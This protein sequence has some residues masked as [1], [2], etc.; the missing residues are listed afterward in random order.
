MQKAARY[1]ERF[2]SKRSAVILREKLLHRNRKKNGD[3]VKVCIYDEWFKKSLTHSENSFDWFP[4]FGTG[5]VGPKSRFPRNR[6]L[7]NIQG[8]PYNPG[9]LTPMEH[10]EHVA[11]REWV[12]TCSKPRHNEM[13]TTG[14]NFTHSS[15]IEAAIYTETHLGGWG[16]PL[17]LTD[18]TPYH[19]YFPVSLIYSAD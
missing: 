13:L 18:T 7:I 10:M 16:P 4:Y 6:K 2:E 12:R 17:L 14:V 1:R 3:D 9:L 8:V 11:Y 15:F 19:L 5:G